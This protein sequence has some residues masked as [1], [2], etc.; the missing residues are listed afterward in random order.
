M[1]DFFL[2][3]DFVKGEE[4]LVRQDGS[5]LIFPPDTLLPVLKAQKIKLKK[6]EDEAG[7][8]R[9]FSFSLD[10]DALYDDVKVLPVSGWPVEII[11][12]HDGGR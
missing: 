7:V 1:A 12:D 2:V 11:P 8:V 3:Q 10:M 6:E 5:H 4:R 9:E